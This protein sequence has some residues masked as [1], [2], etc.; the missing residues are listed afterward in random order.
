MPINPTQLRSNLYKILDQVLETQKP[1]EIVRKG[2]VLEVSVK[3]H[4]QRSK[5][6]NLKPHPNIINGDPENLVQ[7]DWSNYWQGDKEL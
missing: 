7:T 2:Q 6:A 1:V 5:L 4:K 3:Q